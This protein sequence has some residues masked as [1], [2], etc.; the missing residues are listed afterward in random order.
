MPTGLRPPHA[1]LLVKYVRVRSESFGAAD[2]L[3][4][5]GKARRRYFRTAKGFRVTEGIR[6]RLSHSPRTS[7]GSVRRGPLRHAAYLRHLCDCRPR[8]VP[9]GLRPPHAN[10]LV[11][12][13]RV[14]SESFGAADRLRMRGKARRRYF[15]TAKGFNDAD[16]SICMP[17]PGSDSFCYPTRAF[18]AL[19]DPS[20]PA[21]GGSFPGGE[22][23]RERSPLAV[24]VS[25]GR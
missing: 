23:Q 22:A 16:V 4:M 18:F 9:T 7:T 25:F 14:R 15:R 21:S 6:T 12:Y 19:R 8:P 1:N 3:R 24:E 10:L 13:V 5:R 2:R 17:K 11:K 20:S